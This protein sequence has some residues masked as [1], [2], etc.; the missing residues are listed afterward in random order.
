MSDFEIDNPTILSIMRNAF[1]GLQEARIEISNKLEIF[2]TNPSRTIWY[3]MSVEPLESLDFNDSKKS[4]VTVNISHFRDVLKLARSE[5]LT[6]FKKVKIIVEHDEQVKF[7]I[8]GQMSS[9]THVLLHF[10]KGIKKRP[11]Y[12][13]H[14]D[15]SSAADIVID[16]P[17]DYKLVY[18]HFNAIK[19][20]Q[21]LFNEDVVPIVI[22]VKKGFVR[23]EPHNISGYRHVVRGTNS[24]DIEAKSFITLSNVQLTSEVISKGISHL[25]IL[26]LENDPIKFRYYIDKNETNYKGVVE[27]FVVPTVPQNSLRIALQL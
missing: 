14:F 6:G 9:F 25:E 15:F 20:I 26:V 7:E 13:T 17:K 8:E 22:D 18:E 16:P 21:P 23:F 10:P 4:G 5:N 12:L 1:E 11:R 27:Y 24:N 19:N 3:Y 2:G